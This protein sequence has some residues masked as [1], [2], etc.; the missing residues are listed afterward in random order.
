MK[1]DKYWQDRFIELEKA[2]MEYGLEAYRNIEPAFNRAQA[3]IQ[4]EIEIWMH[5]IAVNNNVSLAEARR[6]LNAKELAEFKWGIEEYISHAEQGSK[7]AKQLENA[8]A[9]YHISRLEALQATTQMASEKAF[10]NELDIVDYLARKSYA[11]GYYRT[12]YELQKSFNT[13]FNMGQINEDKLDKLIAKPWAA[14]GRNFSDRIWQNK[15]AM[16]NELNNEL[17]R[18]CIQ[19]KPAKEAVENLT[20]FVD[21]KVRNAKAQAGRLVATEA[22]FFSSVAQKDCFD[23]LGVDADQIGRASCRE[24]V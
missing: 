22:A 17:V 14:D 15:N 24:R 23:D 21:K 8:S 16:V 19:G 4:K 2:T 13:G 6:M 1:N 3:E 11:E 18:T 10:G 7:F 5:R 9:R 20:Q 12:G